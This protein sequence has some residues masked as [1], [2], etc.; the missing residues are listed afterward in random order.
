MTEVYDRR[1]RIVILPV[2]DCI[3]KSYGW[4]RGVVCSVRTGK[5]RLGIAASS[6]GDA[7]IHKR[8]VSEITN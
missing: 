6:N 8:R 1:K 5:K 4:Y 3:D 2:A 7:W